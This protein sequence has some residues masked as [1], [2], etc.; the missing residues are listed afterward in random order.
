MEDFE[1]PL[2]DDVWYVENLGLIRQD[3]AKK[4]MT[5]NAVYWE[6]IPH[7]LTFIMQYQFSKSVYLL[8]YIAPVGTRILLG[9]G[10][11]DLLVRYCQKE[12]RIV[13]ELKVLRKVGRT[14]GFSIGRISC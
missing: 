11:V 8:W 14:L 3:E 5:S 4:H 6:I 2:P 1:K 10:R 12:Q 13:V 7:E 9:M